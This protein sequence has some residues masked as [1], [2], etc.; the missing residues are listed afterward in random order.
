MEKQL[1]GLTAIVVLY[2]V[3]IECLIRIQLLT[4]AIRNDH[5]LTNLS[6][7]TTY[8]EQQ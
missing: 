4:L 2:F 6:F 5:L 1:A 8:Q 7:P 3:T